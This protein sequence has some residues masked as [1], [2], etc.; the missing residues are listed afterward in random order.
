[1]GHR[2]RVERACAAVREGWYAAGAGRAETDCPYR[3][4]GW[5]LRGFWRMGFFHQKQGRDCDGRPLPPSPAPLPTP[6]PAKVTT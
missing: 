5:S 4:G 6:Q 3:E 1:M 2:Q